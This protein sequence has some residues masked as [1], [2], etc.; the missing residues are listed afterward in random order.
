MTPEMLRLLAALIELAGVCGLAGFI[1]AFEVFERRRPS[2][3]PTLTT[4]QVR[5]ALA[6]GLNDVFGKEP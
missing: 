6:P 3:G 1:I 2:R 4:T 5:E